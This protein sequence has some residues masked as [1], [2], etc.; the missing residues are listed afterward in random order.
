MK[1]CMVFPGY[2]SQFV[3]MGKELYDSSRIIQEY[4]EEASSCL[5]KN[6][7]KLCFA[8][9]D[10]DLGRI[11]NAYTAM[12]LV[13]AAIYAL[14][15][16][17]GVKAD[18]V[19]GYNLG[20]YTAL[21]AADGINFPDALY[22]LN[23]YAG[24]YET[25]I[26]ELKDDFS[27]I[28]VTGIETEEM[29]AICLKASKGT[30]QA[31]IALYNLPTDH[32]IAG[33]SDAIE[34][35]RE[36][37]SEHKSAKIKSVDAAVGLHS[38]VMEPVVKNFS[39]YLEKVDFHDLSIPLVSSVSTETISEGK[40]AAESIVNQIHMPIVWDD[41]LNKVEDCDLFIEIGP[42]TVLQ[43]MIKEKYPDKH[44]ISINKEDDI[45]E[46][47]KIVTEQPIE[48]EG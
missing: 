14:L 2:G 29:R 4:F 35:V 21:F 24:F 1:I 45:A 31:H 27:A 44:V 32:V 37:V 43:T 18:I 15:K 11:E 33:H 5:D 40:R 23:K 12:F 16:E 28:R 34:H 20:E 41:L 8:S 30:E 48:T 42:G 13:S 22:L 39:V 26:N 19:A 36:L 10:V 6:F 7:V 3:G 38:S 17:E 25:L 46:L 9:S 47:K